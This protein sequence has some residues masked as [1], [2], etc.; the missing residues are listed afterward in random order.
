MQDE[1]VTRK[2]K[3]TKPYKFTNKE[4]AIMAVHNAFLDTLTP[5]ERLIK[6]TARKSTR[7]ELKLFIFKTK[8]TIFNFFSLGMFEATGDFNRNATEEDIETYVKE[9]R[10]ATNAL[11][12][13]RRAGTKE[14]SPK[15]SNSR[16]DV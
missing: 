8:M 16:V 4:K 3:K 14:R 2:A 10:R 15:K 9:C 12:K 11:Q 6:C 7:D 5:L 1:T 13:N